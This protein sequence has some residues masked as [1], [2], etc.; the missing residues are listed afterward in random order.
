MSGLPFELSWEKSSY[1]ARHRPRASNDLSFHE[2]LHQGGEIK[3]PVA[4]PPVFAKRAPHALES[5]VSTS[6]PNSASSHF[7]LT[8]CNQSHGSI[9]PRKSHMLQSRASLSTKWLHQPMTVCFPLHTTHWRSQS[10]YFF[11]AKVNLPAS[12]R[13]YKV[14]NHYSIFL[15]GKLKLLWSKIVLTSKDSVPFLSSQDGWCSLPPEP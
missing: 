2:K 4:H 6:L 12:K 9:S 10:L 14:L 7:M 11:S 3:K 13:S 5:L 8:A 15:G 1:P